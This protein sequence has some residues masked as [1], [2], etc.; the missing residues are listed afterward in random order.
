LVF[1]A[2]YDGLA[3]AYISSGQLWLQPIHTEE[4]AA[5]APVSA[6]QFANPPVFSQDGQYLA[7]ANGGVWLL[8]LG[9]QET[10]QL[11][12]DVD[13]T[14]NANMTEF[15]LHSPQ[16]FVT[17]EDGRAT[18]LIVDVGVWEWNSAGVY[19]L[20]EDSFV[21]LENQDYMNILP[22][23]SGFT[24]V[25]GNGGIAGDPSLSIAP[26]LDAVNE[27]VRVVSFADMTDAVLFAE[28]AVE[29]A[30]D[31]V[32]V[33]GQS[34]TTEPGQLILFWFDYNLVSGAGPVNLVTVA[35]PGQETSAYGRLSPDGAVM[36]VWINNTF[37]DA[38]LVVGDLVLIDMT[39][40]TVIESAL[41]ETV[42]Q[43]SWQP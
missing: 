1:G 29:I 42:G 18:H 25:F 19:D 34:I 24:M 38:G 41:P 22:L 23:A 21:Q 12:A 36:P 5:L 28:Q 35:L 9:T 13:L 8:D 40:G 17:G 11:L 6:T 3:V 16:E 43:F 32:R 20:T 31:V 10:R 33:Y 30:S 26:S 7:Y 39:T 37:T 14:G 2:S 15:R 27:A 4:A